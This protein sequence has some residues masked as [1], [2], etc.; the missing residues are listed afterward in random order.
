MTKD[1][2]LKLALEAL[3][4]ID[5]LDLG[6]SEYATRALTTLD[7]FVKSTV[8]AVK[9]AL[10]QP[11]QEPPSEWAGIKA[12]LDEYGLQAISFVADWKAAQPMQEPVGNEFFEAFAAKQPKQDQRP[13][14]GLTGELT[15]N[16]LLELANTFYTGGFTEREIAFARVVLAKSK[17]KNT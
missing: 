8:T 7:A 6:L 5:K 11:A 16:E 9:E 14:V 3:E 15:R 17:E 1:E 13:W 10:A 4:A 12:I 2:A